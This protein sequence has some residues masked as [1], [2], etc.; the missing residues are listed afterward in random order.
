MHATF[1]DLKDKTVFITGGGSG[2]GAALTD[3]FL[4][5][6]AR[7]GFVGRSDA[8]AFCDEMEAKHGTRPH[9]VECDITDTAALK[10]AIVEIA[11]TL[12]P[13]QIAV[14]N[15]A[16]DQRHETLSVDE[17]FW[18]WSQAINLKAYFF[19]CQAAIE[20]M[21]KAGGGVIVNFSSISYMMGNEG[22]PAYTTA[23]GGITAMTRS[24]A[25][26]FGRDNIRVNALAPGW[27]MT[28]KQKEMWVTPEA[29]DGML[30]RQCLKR[31]IEP[32]DIVGATLFLASDASRMMTGQLMVVDGGVVTTG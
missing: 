25:R 21:Q 15:A 5:Q 3:G 22:Y 7:V 29:L 31:P 10:A 27:V 12:G 19:G 28:D 1:H 8:T 17:E 23:N 26:E 20:S 18:D 13:I 2:I 9:F 30:D 4:A 6:G 11:D 16:N 14:N 24:L 32:E